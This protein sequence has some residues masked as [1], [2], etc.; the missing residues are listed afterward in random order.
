M[1]NFCLNKNLTDKFLEKLRNGEIDPVKLSEMSSAERNAFFSD[2]LGKENAKQVNA[3]F[4]SKLLLKN[5]QRGM[6]NWAKQ[7]AGMKPAAMRDI[8][9]KVNR[10][11]EVL[12]PETEKAFLADLAEQRL[13]MSVTMEEASHIAELAKIVEEKKTAMQNGG[14]RMEYGAARVAFAKYV[15]EL[16]AEAAKTTV[17]DIV[18]HPISSIPKMISDIAGVAKSVKASFD[19]SFWGRQGFKTLFTHPKI[20]AKNAAQS[21]A[22]IVNSLKGKDVMDAVKADIVSREN[23]DLMQ[24][25]KLA[26]GTLEEA[27]PTHSPEK[28][29]LFGRLYKASETAFTAAAYRMRADVFDK[30]IEIAKKSDVNLGDIKEVRSIGKLVNALT[31]RGDLGRLEGSAGITALN[32]IFFSPRFLKSHIDSM[33]SQPLGI[34]VESFARKQAAVNMV[35]VLAGTSAIITIANAIAPGSVELD[36]R[37][38]DFGKIRV[39]NT[40]F[41]VTGGMASVATLAARLATMKSKSSTTGILS[42]LNSGAFGSQTGMDVVNNFFENKLSPAASI[43]KDLLKGQDF[44]GNPLTIQGELSN[45]FTPLPIATYAELQKDPQSANKLLAIMADS[46]GIAVSDYMPSK[47]WQTNAGVELKQ[48]KEKVG[49]AEFKKANQ[50]FNQQYNEWFAKTVTTEKYKALDDQQ[51]KDALAKK[52]ADIKDAIFKSYGFKYKAPKKRKVP[53]L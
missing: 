37:S 6:I 42:P 53:K 25:A 7:V 24:R 41:D 30:Y 5:Q 19:N 45:L 14:D 21:F 28:I 44:Q 36:P 27:F 1:A 29:P 23:Y 32:N 40:R 52:Q 15:N 49:L 34:G 35:K 10:M 11:S 2:F 43:V 16:T 51:K 39:G 12:T 22:D 13:G 8:I 17:S 4:E 20:W 3:L 38:S 33:I 46:L 18:K 26:T 47:N 50:T 9:S 31:G 48:F